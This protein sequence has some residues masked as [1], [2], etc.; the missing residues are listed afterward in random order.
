M[1]SD[2]SPIG[3]IVKLLFELSVHLHEPATFL[4]DDGELFCHVAY[5][6]AIGVAVHFGFT[7]G[8]VVVPI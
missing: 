5:T 6:V 4:N 1:R 8:V 7:V 2:A 3:G